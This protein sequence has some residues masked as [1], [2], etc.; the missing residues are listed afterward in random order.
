MATE[1]GQYDSGMAEP[2]VEPDDEAAENLRR[3]IER[4]GVDPA[5]L[6]ARFASVAAAEPDPYDFVGSFEY[7]VVDARDVDA[8][9]RDRG[10]GAS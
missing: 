4:E 1:A 5:P 8:F 7:D 6:A 2:T 10:F 3:R 9:L